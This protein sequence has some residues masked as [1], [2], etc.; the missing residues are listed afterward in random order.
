MA[1][2][3]HRRYRS[4]KPNI[5]AELAS[6]DDPQ[7]P[8]RGAHFEIGGDLRQVGVSGD[9]VQSTMLA[10]VGMRLVAGID[11]RPIE[12][13]LEAHLCLEEIRALADLEAESLAGLAQT[14]PPG[15]N[16]HLPRN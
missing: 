15:A 7:H 12:R 14:Y 10:G 9:H 8:G 16:D 3:P 11:D 2:A 6:L 5:A 1:D 13:G 4:L